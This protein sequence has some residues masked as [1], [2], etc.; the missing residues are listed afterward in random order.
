[1][2]GDLGRVVLEEHEDCNSLESQWM[3]KREQEFLTIGHLSTTFLPF[4]CAGIPF[5]FPSLVF[6]MCYRGSCF[7]HPFCHRS[8]HL[9][10]LTRIWSS[11]NCLS[12]DE[13][14]RQSQ[15]TLSLWS[16]FLLRTKHRNLLKEVSRTE[17]RRELPSPTELWC[18]VVIG[19]SLHGQDW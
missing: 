16:V 1:M 3:G 9:T 5:C 12:S 10:R 18:L 4:L 19:A 13:P 6:W 17:A 7:S 14:L 2:G 11:Y 8:L 15:K